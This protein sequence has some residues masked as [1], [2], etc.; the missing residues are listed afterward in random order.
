MRIRENFHE[1]CEL[2]TEEQQK[3]TAELFQRAFQIA[4]MKR[5]LAEIRK[6]S[7]LFRKVF[8]TEQELL[9]EQKTAEAYDS[10]MKWTVPFTLH[11]LEAYQRS[12]WKELIDKGDAG[13]E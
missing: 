13:N 1:D 7:V 3:R 5:L 2:Y 6:Q 9:E 8:L 12:G 11:N 10:K 4:Q